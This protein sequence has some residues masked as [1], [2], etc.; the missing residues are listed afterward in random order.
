MREQNAPIVILTLSETAPFALYHNV[1]E[2]PACNPFIPGNDARFS[3]PDCYN[4]QYTSSLEDRRNYSNQA[5]Y[6]DADV[7]G[8][9]GVGNRG[10]MHAENF[11]CREHEHSLVVTAPPLSVVVFAAE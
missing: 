5:N 2:Y 8:G 7:Y 10:G 6:A 3:N 9:S 1:V 11:A 4:S